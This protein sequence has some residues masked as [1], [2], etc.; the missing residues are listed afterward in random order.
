MLENETIIRDAISKRDAL[1]RKLT[2]YSRPNE[3]KEEREMQPLV[4]DAVELT[5]ELVEDKAEAHRQIAGIY[6]LH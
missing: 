1:I 2:E 3:M 4:F 5:A 6:R